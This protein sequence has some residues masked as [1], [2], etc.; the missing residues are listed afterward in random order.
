MSLPSPIM[1][2]SAGKNMVNIKPNHSMIFFEGRAFHNSEVILP[3]SPSKLSMNQNIFE[4]KVAITEGIFLIVSLVLFL[5]RSQK[6][7]Y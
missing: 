4:T 7:F 3:L 1:G 2:A 6:D 5:T